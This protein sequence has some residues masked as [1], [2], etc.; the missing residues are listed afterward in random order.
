MTYQSREQYMAEVQRSK[1]QAQRALVVY[2]WQMSVGVSVVFAIG[3]Q[4]FKALG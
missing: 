3:Y 2:L 4:I 1:I